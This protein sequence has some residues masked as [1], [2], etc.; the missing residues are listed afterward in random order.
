MQMM[1]CLQVRCEPANCRSTCCQGIIGVDL[2]CHVHVYDKIA[3]QTSQQLETEGAGGFCHHIAG[4]KYDNL[5][6]S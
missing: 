3:V 6:S 1:P 5:E 4:G 2:Q